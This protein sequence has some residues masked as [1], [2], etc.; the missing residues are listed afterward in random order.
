MSVMKKMLC[1]A[2]V[3]AVLPLSASAATLDVSQLKTQVQSLLDQVRQLQQQTGGAASGTGAMSAASCPTFTRALKKG[4]S[5]KDVTALQTYL[6][7]DSSIY[8]EGTVSGYFGALTQAAVQRFQAQYGVVL[9]GTPSTTGYGVVGPKTAAAISLQCSQ[10]G[11][12]TIKVGGYMQVS[13]ITGKGP[14]TVNVQANVNSTESCEAATYVLDW[15]DQSTV[16]QIPVAA[17]VCKAV[18][19]TLSHTYQIPGTYQ[20]ILAAGTHRTTAQ[21]AVYGATQ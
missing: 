16:A 1:A 3:A 19:Q 17:G 18:S 20:I 6:A 21:V 5:G 14:L 7:L 9:S 10:G 12:A 11:G 4:M 15:G 8:P 2:L 13:P